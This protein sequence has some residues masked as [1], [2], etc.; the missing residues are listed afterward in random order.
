[1]FSEIN[2]SILLTLLHFLP[3][4]FELPIWLQY[5][6]LKWFLKNKYANDKETLLFI[7][8]GLQNFYF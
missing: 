6:F 8:F 5:L 2:A 4:K 3:K 7:E 1:M